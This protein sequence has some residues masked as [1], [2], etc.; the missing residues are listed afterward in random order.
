MACESNEFLPLEVLERAKVPDKMF[1]S[2]NTN[3]QMLY[4]EQAEKKRKII[5]SFM[6]SREGN[7]LKAKEEILIGL[8]REIDLAAWVEKHPQRNF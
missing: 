2:F 3:E 7:D 1:F 8:H 4:T 6:E 5:K